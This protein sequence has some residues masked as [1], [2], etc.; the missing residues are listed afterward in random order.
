MN[1]ESDEET[2]SSK[3]SGDGKAQEQR[4]RRPASRSQDG[5]TP[6]RRATS[7]SSSRESSPSREGSSSRSAEERRPAQSTDDSTRQSRRSP[8]TAVSASK[9]AMEQF[10][11]LTGRAPESIVAVGKNEDGWNVKLEVVES[12]RI[13]DSADLL[14]EYDVYLDSTGELLSY[15][16][17]DRYVRGRPSV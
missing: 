15:D 10:S 17:L 12:R 11:A 5:P 7:S 6:E 13:P 16:R 3:P 8:L 1:A 9:K 14:A 4:A 2:K